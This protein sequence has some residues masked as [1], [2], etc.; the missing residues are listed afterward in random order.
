[1]VVAKWAEGTAR[2]SGACGKV[3]LFSPARSSGYVS[4]QIQ[5]SKTFNG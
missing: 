5:R 3:A 1:M 2:R 4:Q